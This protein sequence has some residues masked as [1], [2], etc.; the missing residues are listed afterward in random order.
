MNLVDWVVLLGTM[1]GIATYGSWRTRQVKSLSTYL[2]GSRSIG[3]G[4]IGLSVMATQASA[5]T[6]LSIPGQGF[7]SGIGFVQNYFGLPL[8]LVIVWAFGDPQVDL[9]HVYVRPGVNPETVRDTI[10]RKWGP[11]QALVVLTRQQL[12]DDI[13]RLLRR[14]YFFAY[15]QE[16][17]VGLVAVLGLVSALLISVLQRRREL[18]LL[19]AV[20]ASQVQVLR[21]VLAEALL[22]G[23]I[24]S[25]IGLLV[26]IPLEWYVLRVLMLDEAGFSFPVLVPWTAATFVLASGVLVASLAGM[27]PALQAVRL[28]IPEAIA[29]E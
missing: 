28:R 29:Y 15:A 16:V 1:L 4:T 27:L 22:M 9:Y 25:L 7:E 20:G 12:R 17:V 8:A 21:S 10:T 2:K 5:I 11:S 6:F 23:L 26:G 3:W 14:I 19:R 18:G 13:R 24:G